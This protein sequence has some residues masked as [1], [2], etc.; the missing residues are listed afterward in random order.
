MGKK[1]KKEFGEPEKWEFDYVWN[2]V[3]R[4]F[5]LWAMS[6][7]TRPPTQD[8]VDL[9]DDNWI[10]DLKLAMSIYSHQ[11]NEDPIM[12]LYE[13]YMSYIKDPEAY[14]QRKAFEEA[15]KN[16]DTTGGFLPKK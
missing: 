3:K 12:S 9:Y 8:E 15:S 14:K 16:I 7:F 1:G 6:G 5:W 10:G 13:H 4:G 11:N 2:K